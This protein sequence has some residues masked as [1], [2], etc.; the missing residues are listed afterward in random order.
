MSIRNGSF[1]SWGEGWAKRPKKSCTG[2]EWIWKKEKTVRH[3]ASKGPFTR[4]IFTGYFRCNF[5]GDFDGSSRKNCVCGQ[6]LI[7]FVPIAQAVGM[8]MG[9]VTA[10]TTAIVV[11]MTR[12]NCVEAIHTKAILCYDDTMMRHWDSACTE[13]GGHAGTGLGAGKWFSTAGQNVKVYAQ[14]QIKMARISYSLVPHIP[15]IAHV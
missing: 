10:M 13:I 6:L 12:V 9:I 4:S 15:N 3:R 11:A 1:H 2:I 7:L 5:I 8:P 14:F